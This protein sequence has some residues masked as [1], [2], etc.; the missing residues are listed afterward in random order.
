MV[1]IEANQ[2]LEKAADCSWR[3]NHIRAILGGNGK[4]SGGRDIQRQAYCAQDLGDS[5]ADTD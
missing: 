5:I 3:A 2:G 1:C 4:E